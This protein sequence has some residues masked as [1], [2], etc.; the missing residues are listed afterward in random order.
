MAAPASTD[1]Y[2]TALDVLD[3]ARAL[4]GALRRQGWTVS[5]AIETGGKGGEQINFAAARASRPAK[6]EARP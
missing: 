1:T 3:A 5:L 2:E 4:A 6:P